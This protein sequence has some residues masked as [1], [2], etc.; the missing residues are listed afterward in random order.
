MSIDPIILG[1]LGWIMAQLF[2]MHVYHRFKIPN[3][4]LIQAYLL[5]LALNHWFG[6]FIYTL[7]WYSTS[8]Y[9]YVKNG[10]TLTVYGVLAFA[11]GSAVL[12]PLAIK[13]FRM[14]WIQGK[15]F[16][17]N[18]N[19]PVL[20]IVAGLFLYFALS[21]VLG[22]VPT[23]AAFV[24]SGW[25]LMTAGLCL[26]CWKAW[27][28]QGRRNLMRWLLF[29]ISF[30]FITTLRMGFLGTGSVS[31]ITCL[32]FVSSFYRPRWKVVVAGTL[33]IYLGLSLFVTYLRDRTELRGVIWLDEA[34]F[35][36]RL[37][38]FG[39]TLKNFE[40]FD[41]TNHAHLERIDLRMNQNTFV[42]TSVDYLRSGLQD[43]AKG[44]TLWEA[45]L[46]LIPR[47]F[48]PD[49]PIV[50][51]SGNL[52]SDYTGLSLSEGTSFGIGQVMEFYINFGVPCV[53]LGFFALGFLIALF[54]IA[55]GYRLSRGNW[56]GFAFWFFPGLGFIQSTGSLV[57]VVSTVVVSLIFCYLLNKYLLPRFSG[58]KLFRQ[59]RVPS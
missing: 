55:A 20:S 14:R 28:L 39:E 26:A 24:N 30:P 17:P 47:A 35:S 3:V 37:E 59:K 16:V 33:A 52:V 46:S 9:E 41:P 15:T 43:F 53:I 50:G 23:V 57:E 25:S 21:P 58:R 40:F 48:W 12:A 56:Q 5:N 51:G 11:V 22:R 36:Q 7:P 1:L 18:P 49:K 27:N 45:A 32:V 42:G 54:D 6:A 29:A 8:D 38:K 13:V 19:L 4:G 10:F 2:I 31:L 44:Q 34:P